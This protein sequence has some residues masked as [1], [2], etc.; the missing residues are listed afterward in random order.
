MTMMQAGVVGL[1]A[2]VR[3]GCHIDL[4]IARWKVGL[5]NIGKRWK[6]ALIIRMHYVDEVERVQDLA[7]L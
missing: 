1:R 3:K 4:H 7:E 5:R 6:M 2:M